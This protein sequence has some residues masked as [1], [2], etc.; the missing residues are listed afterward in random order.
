ISK[1]MGRSL[2]RIPWVARISCLGG[3]SVLS[4]FSVVQLQAYLNLVTT[5]CDAISKRLN[6]QNAKAP[7]AISRGDRG[8]RRELQ[9]QRSHGC[10]R[11]DTDEI[12]PEHGCLLR[13][14]N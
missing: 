10:T 1:S 5:Q 7:K 2:G 9:K 4:V 11:I 6:R 13:A 14:W 3:S 8:A 12:L